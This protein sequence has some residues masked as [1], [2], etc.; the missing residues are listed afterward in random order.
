MLLEAVAGSLLGGVVCGYVLHRFYKNLAF[1]AVIPAWLFWLYLRVGDLFH[2]FS[3]E[4]IV[5]MSLVEIALPLLAT[6][7]AIVVFRRFG[8]TGFGSEH[9]T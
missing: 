5:I 7:L 9:D 6:L 4:R 8:R 1:V 2:Y 3:N